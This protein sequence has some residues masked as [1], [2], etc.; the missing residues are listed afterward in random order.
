MVF[1]FLEVCYYAGQVLVASRSVVRNTQ[2]I[3]DILGLAELLMNATDAG[4]EL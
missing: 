4:H 1:K 2:K 3:I